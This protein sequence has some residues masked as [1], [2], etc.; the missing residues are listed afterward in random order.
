MI[1]QTLLTL[2]AAC[3]LALAAAAPALAEQP[4]PVNFHTFDL[5]S[6]TTSGLTYSRGALKLASSGLGSR[7]YLDPFANANSDGVDGSGLYEYGRWTSDAYPLSFPFNELVSSWNA[8]TPVGT[9]VESEVLPLFADG[10]PAKWYVLGRW[11]YSDSDFHRTS[12][13]GQGDADGYVSIDT[14]FA[15]DH[16]AIGYRLRMTLLRRA[17]SA[18]SPTVSRF[19][20][21]ASD[22]TNQKSMFPS[23]TTMTGTTIDL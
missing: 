8:Q 7:S 4:F 20:A 13:G 5:S 3:G 6:G 23:A 17:G 2:A 22:L 15:K 12:V 9:W 21:I 19:S 11:T 18:A 1:R 10:H 16:P 14:F